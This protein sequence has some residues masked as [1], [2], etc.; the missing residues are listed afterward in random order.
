HDLFSVLSAPRWR[1]LRLL[2]FPGALPAIGDALKIAVPAAI[3]GAVIGEWFGAERGLGVLLESAMYNYQIPLLWSAALVSALVSVL[4][5]SA[6]AVVEV[7]ARQRYPRPERFAE[8]A[9]SDVT[10][11]R[12]FAA[13]MRSAAGTLAAVLMIA[14]L[15]QLWITFTKTNSIVMPSPA[16]VL[17]A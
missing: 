8:P 17:L 10:S 16:D 11:A 14:L 15:W 2:Q 1:R 7:S 3:L 4:G 12:G 13:W 5:Y 9:P 6:A